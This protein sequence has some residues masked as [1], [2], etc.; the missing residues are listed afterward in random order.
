[1]EKH[2]M[3]ALM[4]ALRKSKGMTQQDVAEKIG[5]SNKTVSKWECDDGYPDITM[6]PVIAEI[7]GITVDELLKGEIRNEEK[8]EKA[9]SY[10]KG[11]KQIE[12][13]LASSYMKFKSFSVI[14]V[15]LSAFSTIIGF[16][17]QN[18]FNVYL[19]EETAALIAL[20]VSLIFA[21]AGIVI[22]WY[23]ANKLTFSFSSDDARKCESRL[24]SYLKSARNYIALILC[25]ALIGAFTGIASYISAYY[26]EDYFTAILVSIALAV[27]VSLILFVLIG[28]KLMGC[29]SNDEIKKKT[30]YDKKTAKR[31]VI[32]VLCVM[33]ATGVLVNVALNIATTHSYV[34]ENKETYKAFEQ[35]ALEGRLILIQKN[36]ETLTVTFAI[37][38]HNGQSIYTGLDLDSDAEYVALGEEIPLTLNNGENILLSADSVKFK[39]KE[40]MD[41]FIVENCVNSDFL[42]GIPSSLLTDFYSIPYFNEEDLTVKY[43][44]GNPDDIASY[45]IVSAIVI[46]ILYTAVYIAVRY[47]KKKQL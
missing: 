25:F 31:L 33:T 38:V 41:E 14:A 10:E 13:M 20:G 47:K 19:L 45:R 43:S 17:M 6:L 46:G 23:A 36:D 26:D 27:L 4:A 37:P 34:F 39:S 12:F 40:K 16:I 42:K 35:Y 32:G 30:D 8:A 7:F 11:I 22:E 21:A 1:M 18:I 2:T 29:I 15:G 28:N 44:T 24:I 3:G 9:F 5:I